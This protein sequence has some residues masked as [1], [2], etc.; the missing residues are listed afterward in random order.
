MNEVTNKYF[1]T[2]DK[3]LPETHLREPEFT[4]SAC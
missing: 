2:G 3:F 4:Y 1:L